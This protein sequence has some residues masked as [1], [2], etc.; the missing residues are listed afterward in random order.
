M[1][2]PH[3][4]RS[5]RVKL[6]LWYFLVFTVIQLGL[7]GGVVLFRRDVI[8]RSIDAN[9]RHSAESMVDNV[10]VSEVEWTGDSLAPLVPAQSNFGFFVIRGGESGE[11]LA[12][13]NV[14]PGEDVPFSEWESVPAGPVGPVFSELN[15]ETARRLGRGDVGLRMVTV[16]FRSQGRLYF[17]QAAVRDDTLER[18]LG[19]FFYLVVI[20]VPLGMIAALH[21]AWVIAGRAV[22]PVKRL[23][24]AAKSVSPT[25]LGERLKVDTTDDEIARLQEEHNSALERL[26]AGFRGQDQF[27]SNVSHELRTP[28]AVLL[29]ESQVMGFGEQ[30]D[31]R[32][33]EFAERVE[34]E[35]QRL[36]R[37]VDSFLTLTRAGL[38][39]HR[40][41][42]PVSVNDVLLDS[43]RHCGPFA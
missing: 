37:I 15:R 40:P 18:L 23:S 26:E 31:A 35:M 33:R 17:F 8:R 43:V 20:G 9:L 11:T 19:P 24:R 6:T 25:S 27:V 5:L 14:P 38:D 39:Q 41:S 2:T 4:G 29:T 3:R 34:E 32:W 7:V 12:E 16:P 1:A 28:I 13:W 22:D 10:L 42:D 36:G 21:A 30:D